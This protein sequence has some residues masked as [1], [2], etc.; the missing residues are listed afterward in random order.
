MKKEQDRG[1]GMLGRGITGQTLF[2]IPLPVI[3]SFFDPIFLTASAG[4]R[5]KDGGKKMKRESFV[6][7]PTCP[8]HA[9]LG[10][11]IVPQCSGLSRGVQK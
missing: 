4:S 11:T 8:V 5:Q 2:P 6:S 3:P 7:R 9:A 10:L 1:R